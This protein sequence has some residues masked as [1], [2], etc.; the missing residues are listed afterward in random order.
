MFLLGTQSVANLFFIFA[1]FPFV[2]FGLNDM[3][4]QPFFIVIGV[5]S[6]IL[7]FLT[8]KVHKTILYLLILMFLT[9]FILLIKASNMDLILIRGFASYTAFFITLMVSIEYF[10]RYGLPIKTIVWSNIIY[11]LAAII[12]TFSGSLKNDVFNFLVIS[13]SFWDPSR[14]VIGLTPEPTTFAILLF[15]LS[16]VYLIIYDYQPSSKIKLLVIANIMSILFLTKSS[17]VFVFLLFAAFFYLIKNIKKKKLYLLLIA[18][19][20]FFYIYIYMMPYLFPSSRFVNLSNILGGLEG[21][22]FDRLKV[23]IHFDASI[24]DRVLNAIFPYFG[25]L[26]NYGLP[27][28]VHSF[29]DMSRYL[30]GYFDGY[31]WAGLGSNK[32][33]S[34]AGAFIYELGL[35]GVICIIYMYGLLRDKLN[36]NRLIELFFLFVLLNSS[37]PVSFPLISIMMAIMYYKKNN[38][39]NYLT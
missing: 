13:N 2:S 36:P 31:F 26:A 27:G 15:F 33:L 19:L 12:Q 6:S 16:W 8:G 9:I 28:G 25:F 4:T 29:F 24:N 5:F 18:T 1:L 32:I 17:M 20:L 30:V 7:F 10:R 3:D 22:Y 34:F 11:L 38:H 14:G 37:I 21:D 35:F 23:I 39:Q